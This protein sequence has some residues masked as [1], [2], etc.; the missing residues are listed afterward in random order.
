MAAPLAGPRRQDPRRPHPRRRRW[1]QA[2]LRPAPWMLAWPLCRCSLRRPPRLL[3]R[4]AALLRTPTVTL[5]SAL[6]RAQQFLLPHLGRTQARPRRPTPRHQSRAHGAPPWSRGSRRSAMPQASRGQAASGGRRCLTCFQR[7]AA[8]AARRPA[9][10]RR[11]PGSRHQRARR[12]ARQPGL[13]AL[14]R[15]GGPR[16]AALRAMQGMHQARGR[17]GRGASAAALQGRAPVRAR[18]RMRRRPG[19]A[20]GSGP[21]RRAG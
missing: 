5:G 2:D 12:G 8:A 9:L 7:R 1:P 14:S 3:S 21:G 19:R 13:T 18:L 11:V 20:R 16:P 15:A 17:R 10:L 6:V 4:P